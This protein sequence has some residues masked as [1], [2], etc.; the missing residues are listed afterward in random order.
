MACGAEPRGNRSLGVSGAKARRRDNYHVSPEKVINRQS[1]D[2][3]ESHS[4]SEQQR[5]YW[6]VEGSGRQC[7]RCA[8]DEAFEKEIRSSGLQAREERQEG[9]A[10]VVKANQIR[11]DLAGGC[12]ENAA[13]SPFPP[14]HRSL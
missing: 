7:A 12:D 5:A 10:V 1:A 9:I 2:G 3:E 4:A 6:R 11:G 14:D 8:F 13:S